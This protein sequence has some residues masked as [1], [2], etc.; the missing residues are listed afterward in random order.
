MHHKLLFTE[1]DIMES[2]PWQTFQY[3]LGPPLTSSCPRLP[4]KKKREKTGCHEGAVT[5]MGGSE[6]CA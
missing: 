2:D 3:D 5:F 6:D 4:L 1:E